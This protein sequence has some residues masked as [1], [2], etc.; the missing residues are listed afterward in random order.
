MPLELTGVI[1]D[2]AVTVSPSKLGA[3]PVLIT[4]S[5]QTVRQ[6]VRVSVGG[7]RLR[8]VLSNAFGTSPVEIGA[9]HVA[10]REHDA[11]VKASSVKPLTDR[12]SVV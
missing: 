1:K 6:I 5:N 2:D 8:V 3:G 11:V 7:D 12:K 4:I 10:L 9:A